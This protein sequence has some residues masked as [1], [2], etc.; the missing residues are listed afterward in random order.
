MISCGPNTTDCRLVALL[1]NALR[2][3]A[4][5][6]R[7]SS[8]GCCLAPLLL[9]GDLTFL[10]APLRV[11]DFFEVEEMFDFVDFIDMREDT[12]EEVEDEEMDEGDCV[13]SRRV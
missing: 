1:K 12:D 6:K 13:R 4:L 8:G 10:R 3:D 2:T 5:S 11:S 7:I 9:L